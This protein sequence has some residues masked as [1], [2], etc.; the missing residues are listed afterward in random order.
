M[1]YW[2]SFRP[3][4]KNFEA[5]LNVPERRSRFQWACLR[6][7]R[8]QCFEEKFNSYGASLYE[9]RW[10]EVVKFVK[11]VIKILKVLVLT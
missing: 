1:A 8:Y 6:N 4:F 5:F 9:A 2:D 11:A 7:T 3:Q 10:K